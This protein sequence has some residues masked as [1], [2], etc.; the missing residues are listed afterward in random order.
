MIEAPK[1]NSKPITLPEDSETGIPSQ[2]DI[3]F[4]AALANEVSPLL[5][6]ML[7]ARDYADT[8]RPK[9]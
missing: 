7:V 3:M 9:N 8:I 1:I 5:F 6:A 2:S 4:A